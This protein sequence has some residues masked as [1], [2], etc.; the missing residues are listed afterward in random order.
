MNRKEATRT[1]GKKKRKKW[2][3]IQITAI[4]F[5]KKK[6]QKGLKNRLK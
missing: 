2:K 4:I 3:K 1:S 5:S 6:V